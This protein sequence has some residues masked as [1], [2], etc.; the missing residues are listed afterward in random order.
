LAIVSQNVRRSAWS[1]EE[2]HIS[3]FSRET[4]GE[5]SPDS[6]QLRSASQNPNWPSH[7]SKG[8]RE[9]EPAAYLESLK[10][11]A[12]ELV[13][14]AKERPE[15]FEVELEKAHGTMI[16]FLNHAKSMNT[17]RIEILTSLMRQE[18]QL[19]LRSEMQDLIAGVRVDF[20]SNGGVQLSRWQPG[21]PAE[22]F[23]RLERSLE[24]AKQLEL[25]FNALDPA[26]LEQGP[27]Q[28]YIELSRW[29]QLQNE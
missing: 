21:S 10:W 26:S 1:H 27:S 28:A 15:A 22:Y 12:R 5:F 11:V 18:G 3:N 6:G 9:D 24:R 4:L 2:V 25:L 7:Y 17:A 13:R 14:K 29:L 16:E 23:G 8:F 20:R 19:V